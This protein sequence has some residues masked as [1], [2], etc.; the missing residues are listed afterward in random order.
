[1]IIH[2]PK[3]SLANK[4]VIPYL[5]SSSVSRFVRNEQSEGNFNLADKQESSFST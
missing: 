4:M 1:M 5:A 2:I 3:E